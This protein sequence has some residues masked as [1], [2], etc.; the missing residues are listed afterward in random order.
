M[1]MCTSWG[2]DGESEVVQLLTSELVTNGLL[3]ARTELRV[4]LALTAAE[5]VVAVHDDDPRLPIPRG[6]RVDLLADIDTVLTRDPP[7][8]VDE[9][10]R[11]MEVGPAGSISA[12]RG[13]LLVE[14]L[15][16]E[17]GVEQLAGGKNVWFR[18]ARHS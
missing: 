11:M 7:V 3:H 15:A 1:A 16:D 12:G 18:V 8:T 2:L 5:V 14:S 6:D 4:S 13:L 10:H 17:W 9:R